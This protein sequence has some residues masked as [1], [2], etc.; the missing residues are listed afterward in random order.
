M[1]RVLKSS[2][3]I[4]FHVIVRVIRRCIDLDN[5]DPNV[6]S[7]EAYCNDPLVHWFPPHKCHGCPFFQ[8]Y[9]DSFF[10]PSMD[11]IITG[12]QDRLVV[13]CE[14]ATSCPSNFAKAEDVQSVVI[15][16]PEKLGETPSLV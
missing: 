11:F 3:K 7:Q 6:S 9:S 1:D 16:L 14:P 2:V 10:M 13:A 12:K 15:K 4:V 5:G 8:Y